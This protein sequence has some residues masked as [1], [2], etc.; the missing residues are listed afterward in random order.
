MTKTLLVT[1][2]LAL[3][4]SLL[5]AQSS[6]TFAITS[7]SANNYYWGNIKE[8][9]LATGSFTKTLFETDITPYLTYDA[10]T[11]QQL[12]TD[13]GKGM[14]TNYSEKP[15]A[16][17]VAASAYDAKHNRLY[18]SPMHQNQIRYIDLSSNEAKFFY[19]QQPMIANPTGYLSEE[20]HLT[21]MVLINKVG[22]AITN[23]GNHLYQFTTSKNATVTDLG[24]LIDDANN[25]ATSVHNKCTSWGGD[26]VATTDGLL[27]LITANKHVFTIDVASKIATYKGAITGIPATYTTNGA[28]V[29][30]A[31]K[32]V[33]TSANAAAGLYSL[34]AETL[35]ATTLSATP[36]N[37]SIS[38]LANSNLLTVAKK[39]N[40]VPVE[41]VKKVNQVL[42]ANDKINIY[43]NPVTNGMFNLNFDEIAKGYYA[44]TVTNLMGMQ[45]Y[46]SRINV[47]NESQIVTINL[48][49][50]PGNG[51][52]LVKVSNGTKDVYVGKLIVE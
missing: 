18:Y 14:P 48:G 52:Y 35:I 7:P 40:N 31:N 28:V 30:D 23:D 16:Y 49:R 8:I 46:T 41:E 47:Q 36:T 50:K 22:Y 20:N 1:S 17:G 15:M 43:P 2:V 21:R 38:D 37:V 19:L 3:S 45:L 6:R 11:K 32:I 27:Y 34:D 9:N 29:N 5:T 10:V 44:V 4:A 51:L 24:A 12:S 25:G 42:V 26:V 39:V 33:L 13:A